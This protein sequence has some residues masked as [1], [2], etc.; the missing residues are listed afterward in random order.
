MRMNLTLIYDTS[1]KYLF[2]YSSNVD[3]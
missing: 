3:L 1:T 2:V